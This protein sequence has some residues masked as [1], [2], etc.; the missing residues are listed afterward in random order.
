A[1]LAYVLECSEVAARVRLHRATRRLRL[2]MTV[3]ARPDA[4]PG[5]VASDDFPTSE[6]TTYVPEIRTSD[7]SPR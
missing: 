6:P 5:E 1:A 7:G 3:P 2:M 4:K